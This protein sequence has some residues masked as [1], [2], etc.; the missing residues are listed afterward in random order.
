MLSEEGIFALPCAGGVYKL[1]VSFLS[2][3]MLHTRKVF[4]YQN[5]QEAGKWPSLL[6]CETSKKVSL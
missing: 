5:Y 2:L 6:V 4:I 3:D 1:Y